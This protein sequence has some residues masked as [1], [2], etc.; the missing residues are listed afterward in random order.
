MNR[1]KKKRSLHR[2]LKPLPLFF[3]VLL[4]AW[5]ALIALF[6]S[7]VSYDGVMPEGGKRYPAGEETVSFYEEPLFKVP[8]NNP[9]GKLPPTVFAK[10]PKLVIV[11]DDVKNPS[12]IQAIRALGYPV[13]P[14]IF[15]PAADFPETPKLAAGLEDYLIHLPLEAVRDSDVRPATLT[16]D[17]SYRTVEG[18]VAGVMRDFPN[19]RHINNH[20]GSRF[21]SDP[22]AMMRLMRALKKY[23]LAFLDSMTTN[24]SQGKKISASMGI[25]FRARDVFL[26][27]ESDEAF[28]EQQ[29]RKAVQIAQKNGKAIAIGHARRHTLRVLKNREL[30]RGVELVYLK[31]Y[32][33]E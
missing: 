17:D 26:D 15:P 32:P 20:T 28:I 3:L 10:K 6:F 13:T 29:I 1:K 11:I 16:V 19:L 27:N 31:D 14:A 30:F 24:K 7:W 8:E 9:F 5:I 18:V 12:E 2:V 23:D 33:Y 21:T 4:T 25:P 22:A